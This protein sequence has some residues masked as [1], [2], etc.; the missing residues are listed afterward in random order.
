MP[1]DDPLFYRWDKEVPEEG[2]DLAKVTQLLQGNVPDS[3][4][5][6]RQQPFPSTCCMPGTLRGVGRLSPAQRGSAE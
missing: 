6:S 3:Q 2:K 1:Y 5:R 4:T